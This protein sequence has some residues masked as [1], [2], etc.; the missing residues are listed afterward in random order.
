M[1]ST[2][3]SG[4]L[5][6]TQVY[7]SLNSSLALLRAKVSDASDELYAWGSTFN[8]ILGQGFDDTTKLFEASPTKIEFPQEEEKLR[9]RQVSVGDYHAALIT[10]TRELFCWGSNLKG[11][12]GTED[13]ENRLRPCKV[14][15]DNDIASS[16]SVTLVSCGASFTFVVTD[17]NQ[18]K[19]SGQLP[20]TVIL[21]Q[22]LGE[23]D[24][25]PTFQ[26][27]AQ[28]DQRVKILQIE[29]SR[30]ASIVVDPRDDEQTKELFFWGRSPVG[31]F[32]ELTA[33]NQLFENS[34][35]KDST[36]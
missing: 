31:I 33:L 9:I 25:V 5:E 20:F 18:I 13:T 30:F 35:S 36:C 3:L 7:C 10:S 28:F 16:K 14:Q 29:S 34:T 27:I 11:Q 12:L 8:G 17:Q 26:S 23:Q 22:A 4:D 24:F 32:H 19:V 21:D 15:Y 6:P 1:S 2:E